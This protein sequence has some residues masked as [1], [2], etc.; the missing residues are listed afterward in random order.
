ME[1][2]TVKSRLKMD[3]F[4]TIAH[5]P[6]Y[7]SMQKR[8]QEIL[9]EL[10]PAIRQSC[11][12]AE[13]VWQPYP[14]RVYLQDFRLLEDSKPP[15]TFY[16]L[17]ELDKHPLIVK[18]RSELSQLTSLSHPPKVSLNFVEVV[19]SSELQDLST[20][21]TTD[22]SVSRRFDS[23]GDALWFVQKDLTAAQKSKYV[24]VLMEWSIIENGQ[25][26]KQLKSST[27]DIQVVVFFAQDPDYNLNPRLLWWIPCMK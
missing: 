26:S 7:P 5:T 22:I 17:E 12:L 18:R 9:T 27:F 4:D 13:L 15:G 20:P 25:H 8:V 10:D 11:T 19:C 16:S 23:L 6:T 2:L 14:D 3:L 21:E 1:N 24:N